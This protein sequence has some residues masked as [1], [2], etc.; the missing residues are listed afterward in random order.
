MSRVQ[1]GIQ[2]WGYMH[3]ISAAQQAEAGRVGAGAQPGRARPP[4]KDLVRKTM[5]PTPDQFSRLILV[6]VDSLILGCLETTERSG[7]KVR[8]SRVMVSAVIV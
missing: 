6:L 2:Q 7:T 3:G 5:L 1:Q 4:Q 8:A